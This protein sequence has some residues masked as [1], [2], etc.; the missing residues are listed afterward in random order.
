MKTNKRTVWFLTLL[1][2]VAVISIYYLNKQAPM[3]F[4]GMKIFSDSSNPAKLEEVTKTHNQQPVFAESYLFEE[5]RMG[6]RNERSQMQAQLTSKLNASA[7]SEEMNAVYD[8]MEQLVK[9]ESAET[10]LEMQIIALGY[11]D[12]FVRAEAGNVKVTVLSEDGHSNKQASEITHLVMTNWEGAKKVTV[13]F[14][15]DS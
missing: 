14:K 1:S 4:D 9:Q 6:V 3:P 10:L 13:D 7:D 11:A 8:E 5:M 2:L 12:A 15:G